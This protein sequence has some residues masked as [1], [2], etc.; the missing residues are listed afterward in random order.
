[1]IYKDLYNYPSERFRITYPWIYW[2]NG[3]TPEEIDKMCDYFAEQGVER[4]TTVG[5][6]EIG[7]NGEVIIKQEPNEKVRKSNVKFY[8]YEPANENTNWIFQRLNWILQQANNQFYGFDLNG[9]ESFQ[10][11]EYDESENGRYDFHTDTIYGKNMPADMIE[12]RK[13]SLTFCLNQAGVDYEGGDFQINTGQEKDAETAPAVKGR[14]LIFPSFIIHR[15]A[16]VTKGKRKSLV[17]WTMGP[18]FK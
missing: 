4:G 14:A 6:S 13:L 17:V 18:K 11:T 16:P 1:M 5:A 15:V 7:P 9:F 10:Y 2:D 12:T 3:F 8:N